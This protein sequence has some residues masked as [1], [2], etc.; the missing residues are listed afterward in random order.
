MVKKTKL[1]MKLNTKI[2]INTA[3][4]ISAM[5]TS[6][7]LGM[8]D[9]HVVTIPWN[10]N[11]NPTIP[12]QQAVTTHGIQHSLQKQQQWNLNTN[13]LFKLFISSL[14][15]EKGTYELTKYIAIIITCAFKEPCSV[16]TI[17]YDYILDY[18]CIRYCMKL[19][20]I[21]NKQKPQLE[22]FMFFLWLPTESI[23]FHEIWEIRQICS[24]TFSIKPLK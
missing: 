12:K 4:T 9:T 24:T 22:I 18:S 13:C 23:C 5:Q 11:S 16:V 15:T 20:Q 3:D 8:A 19:L 14:N 6:K 2:V 1:K 7:L 21:F 10:K 17:Q